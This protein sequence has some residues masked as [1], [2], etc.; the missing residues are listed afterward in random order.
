MF[1]QI[2]AMLGDGESRGEKKR[3]KKG[4]TS[5]SICHDMVV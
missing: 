5:V 1:I 3:E 4:H 2:T